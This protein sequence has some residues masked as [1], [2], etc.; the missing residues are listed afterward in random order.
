MSQEWSF[1][2]AH[3]DDLIGRYEAL[4]F[5]TVHASLLGCLPEVPATI[6]DVGAGT[7]RDAAWLAE[8]GH[9]VVALEPSSAMLR[10]AQSLHP[11]S[12]IRWVSG[13][14]PG[15]EGISRSGVTF[16]LILVSAVWMH[17]LPADRPRALR[18]LAGL[19]APGGRIAFSLRHGPDTEGRNFYPVTADEL[20]QGAMRQGLALV[21]RTQ[22]EDVLQRLGV[23]WETLVF[24]L[25]DDATGALPLL[26]SFILRDRKSSTYKLAL[27]RVLCRVAEDY[28]GTALEAESF[29]AEEGTFQPTVELP[30]GLVGLLWIRAYLP[31]YRRQL[32]Q[33]PQEAMGFS[34][35]LER[36]AEVDPQQLRPGISFHG[37]TAQKL[38]QSLKEACETIRIMPARYLTFP[39]DGSP[40]FT[41]RKP[42]RGPR[43]DGST[44]LLLDDAFLWS[45]GSFQVPANLWRAF[46]RLAP[47]IE[48]LLRQEWLE[49]MAGL[50][51]SVSHQELWKALEWVDPVRDTLEVRAHAERILSLGQSLYCVWTGD[52]LRPGGFDI[53]HC[54]PMA[55]WPCQ[56]LWNLMPAKPS[57]N[58]NKRDRLVKAERLE[59]A[60]ER[61][62]EWW[63]RAYLNESPQLHE[64]FD[65]E[66]RVTLALPENVQPSSDQVFQGVAMKRLALSRVHEMQEW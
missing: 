14:L 9:Q 7:G 21:L 57:V 50:S 64:R 60:R 18:K 30:L 12:N 42:T 10:A 49:Y 62:L 24:Q 41:I 11:H 55:A 54:F 17:V 2:D 65:Y 28:P 59:A 40:V 46:R 52:R 13:S 6:L 58:R 37:E 32:P 53:D 26:R 31:L 3:A 1:Y 27:L 36:L 5:E 25:P 15:L 45:L 47:W 23:R 51:G 44:V 20:E 34:R 22:E 66:A 63:E 29:S 43:S 16:D 56:D 19:L 48:P 35:I 33:H 61:I 38:K 4:A 39:G 8:R